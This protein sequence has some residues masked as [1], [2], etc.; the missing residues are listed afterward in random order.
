MK[1]ENATVLFLGDSITEGCG[2]DCPEHFFVNVLK[3]RYRMANAVNYGIGGTR[4]AHQHTP[5]NPI[6]D[7]E[8][9]TR[10][11]DMIPN[12]DAIVVFGG[13]NDYGHGDAPIGT[14]TD[15]TADTFYGA[16]HA[17]FTALITKYPTAH[18]LV[19]T[20][21]H[22]LGENTPMRK[23]H[24]TGGGYDMPI[25]A[26][27]VR[28]IREVAERFSLPVCDLFAESG[29]QPAVPIIQTLY[30]PDGLHPNALGHQRLA[31]MIGEALS[32]L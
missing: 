10:V 13:T 4:I 11:P 6:F 28:I 9:V 30:M 20:P 5:Y 22:R 26:D 1:L 12:A 16:C 21:T 8:Y 27:Y 2:V 29:M 32:R 17:L 25:L 15:T 7:H 3:E 14:P 18:I 24:L 31:D 23:D 19:L